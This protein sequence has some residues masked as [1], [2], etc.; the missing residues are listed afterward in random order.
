MSV[1]RKL[2]L[3]LP[4]VWLLGNQTLPAATLPKPEEALTMLRAK[5]FAEL[6]QL[7]GDLRREKLEFYRDRLPP[8][9]RFYV[10]LQL[11]R[12]AD[13]ATWTNHFVLLNQWAEA[14]PDSP[15]ALVAMGAN[16]VKYAWKARE[17]AA[18]GSGLSVESGR[19]FKERLARARQ[20]LEKAQSLTVKDPEGYRELIVVATG[21]GQPRA[22]MELI[23]TKGVELDRNYTPIYTAKAYY[24]L[25]QWKGKPGEW[26]AFAEEVGNARG[27]EEGDMLYMIIARTQS[28][29]SGWY[30]FN[31]TKASYRR[32]Q[33]GFEASL[34]RQPDNLQ[35][36]NSYCRITCYWGDQAQAKALFKRIN[37][38]WEAADWGDESGFRSWENWAVHN[39]PSPITSNNPRPTA[40][41]P[42]TRPQINPFWVL[43]IA[44]GIILLGTAFLA[45]IIWNRA[46][47]YRKQR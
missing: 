43:G 36:L 28:T 13:D 26:E 37:G 21:L 10:S 9:H 8:L 5:R 31:R 15:S 39:G 1:W 29:Y 35:E 17:N 16:Y 38:R 20:V 27:G 3:C 34:K 19:L 18:D 23:F 6:E 33:R 14:Y 22:E 24:L 7:S 4:A 46:L 47:Q 40:A 30:F 32:M 42:I 41:P 11:N 45:L 44:G 2:L 12:E 25:P